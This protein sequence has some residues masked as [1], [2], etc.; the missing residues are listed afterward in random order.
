M[1]GGGSNGGDNWGVGER[2]RGMGQR[3]GGGVAEEDVGSARDLG[4]P[5]VRRVAHGDTGAVPSV[6]GVLR[7][8][9]VS[10]LRILPRR[11]LRLL[12]QAPWRFPLFLDRQVLSYL[13]FPLSL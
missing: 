12:R 7:G 1:G 10:S 13:S 3:D 5:G 4:D 9:S 11:S 2:T 6:R 8:G